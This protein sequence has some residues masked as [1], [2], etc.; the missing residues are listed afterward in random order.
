MS[1]ELPPRPDVKDGDRCTVVAGRHAGKSGIVQ[2]AHLSKSGHLSISVCQDD[3]VRFKT[4]A[5]SVRV[6]CGDV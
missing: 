5:K 4:L 6:E 1:S 2:D 3:G